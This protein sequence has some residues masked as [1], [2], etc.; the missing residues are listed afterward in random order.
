MAQKGVLDVLNENG[1]FGYI[2]RCEDE[3]KYLG[4]DH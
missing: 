2:L 4:M 1:K 3:Y